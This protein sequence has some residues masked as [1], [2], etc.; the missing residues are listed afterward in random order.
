MKLSNLN[1]A[2]LLN[3]A[4]FVGGSLSNIHRALILGPLFLISEL[5]TVCERAIGKIDNKLPIFFQD[6]WQK[7]ENK[8]DELRKKGSMDV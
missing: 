5:G 4:I 1:K 6:F 7:V 2:R 8:Q 3:V